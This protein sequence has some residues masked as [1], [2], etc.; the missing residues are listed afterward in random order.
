METGVEVEA[1]KL[2]NGKLER[3]VC[4]EGAD[5]ARLSSDAGLKNAAARGATQPSQPGLFM[6]VGRSRRLMNS[7]G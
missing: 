5:D 1:I 3:V 4:S 6:S 7:A 2:S